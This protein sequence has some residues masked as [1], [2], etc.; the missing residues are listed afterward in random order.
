VA[1]IWVP[2]ALR[3]GLELLRDL[4]EDDSARLT[5]EVRELPT[6]L[7]IA[8]LVTGIGSALPDEKQNLAS[9]LVDSLIGLVTQME[10]L[11]WTAQ[12]IADATSEAPGVAPEEPAKRAVFR[13]RLLTILEARSVRSTARASDLLIHHE[14]AFRSARVFTDI[15]PVFG[16]DVTEAPDGAVVLHMLEMNYWSNGEHKSIYL[17]LDRGDLERLRAVVDR[18]LTKEKTLDPILTTASLKQFSV[19]QRN[20]QEP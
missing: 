18:A 4:S 8:T 7:P 9:E 16:T 20:S 2:P 3:P 1:S 12:Q 15:R 10:H 11:D 14:R 13:D 5:Q 6:F 17:A 19:E